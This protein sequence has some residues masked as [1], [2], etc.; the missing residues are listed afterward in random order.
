[1]GERIQVVETEVA[2]KTHALNLGDERARGYPR[3]YV[4]ADVVLPLEAVRIIAARLEETGAPAASPSMD[5]DLTG[6]SWPV[7]AFYAVWRRM[8]YTREGMIGVGVYVLTEAG[9]ARFDR[10]PDV[11]ADD[12]FVR[13]HFAPSERILVDEARVRVVAPASLP[14]LVRV[15]TR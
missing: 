10:F 12:G 2:S 11:V 13:C 4:D 8:P 3:F 7:R 5:V 15:K 9:R 6:S 1:F 14:D